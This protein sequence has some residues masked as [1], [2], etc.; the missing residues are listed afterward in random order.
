MKTKLICLLIALSSATAMWA[1]RIWFENLCYETTSDST[2][3]VTYQ[4]RLYYGTENNYNKL[5]SVIIPSSIHD[6]GYKNTY[7]VTGIG[8]YTFDGCKGLTSIIIP[9]GITY[10]GQDAFRGCTGL[11][12]ITMPNSVTRVA[13]N[14]LDDT[15][16]YK[17]QPDELVYINNILYKYKGTMPNNTNVIIKEGTAA[18]C[19]YAFSDC[20]GLTSISIPNSVTG[21]GEHV[22]SGCSGLTSIVVE[23][24][25]TIY[26]SRN[27]CNAII[28]TATNTLMHGCGTTIIPNSVTSI[29]YRA[30]FG[31]TGLTS[32]T[33]PNSVTSIDTY[34]FSD[35]TH[36]TSVTIPNS[37][38]SIGY[39]AFSG[40]TGL[41]SITLP[42]SVTS[43]GNFAFEGCCRLYSIDI[44]NSVTTIGGSAFENCRSLTSITI[45]SNVERVENNAFRGCTSLTSII[46]NA[47]ECYGTDYSV[48]AFKDIASQITSINFGNEV[49]IV[50]AFL[51]YGMQNLTTITLSKSVTDIDEGAFYECSSLVS[52]DI[53]NSVKTIRKYAFQNCTSL[54]SIVISN[55]VTDIGWSAFEGCSGLVSIIIPNSVT[56]IE[57][58]A[59][60]NCTR[61]ASVTLGDNVTN[62]GKEAF[63]GTPWF[64]NFYK[65]QPNGVVY[66]SK[67]LYEYKGTMPANTHLVVK[68]GTAGIN[69]SAF[70]GCTNLVSITIPN[71]VTSIGEY[72]FSGCTGLTSITFPD[73]ITSIGE[74]AFSGCTGLTSITIPKNIKYIGSSAFDDCENLTSV[75]WNA[76]NCGDTRGSSH[77]GNVVS[78][79]TSFT[80]GDD[81]DSI[82]NALFKG[83]TRLTSITIP[84][85]VRK[86][87]IFFD[88]PN[89]TSVVWNAQQCEANTPFY[90]IA[91]QITSFTFGDDVE[92]I[93]KFLCARMSNLTSITIPKGVKSIGDFAFDDCTSLTSVSIG[94]GVTYIGGFSGCSALKSINI[95]KGVTYLGGFRNCTSLTSITLPDGVKYIGDCSGCTALKS[96][97]LPNSVTA[98]EGFS[99]CTAL[100]S[101]AIPD[102]ITDI[103]VDAFFNCSSLS[104]VTFGKSVRTIG[105]S[106]F[107]GCERL[108]SIAFPDSVTTI[109]DRAFNRCKRLAN[110][111][112]PA[113]LTSFGYSVFGEQCTSLKNIVWNVRKAYS[114]Y[115]A[116]NTP[117]YYRVV[118]ASKGEW[119]DI[120]LRS[121][122]VSFTF[123]NDVESIPAGLCAG[124]KKM[125][126]VNLGNSVKSIESEAFYGCQSI[127][128]IT[129]PESLK[130]IGYC[131]FSGCTKIRTKI[132]IPVN[133]S[134][135][136]EDAFAACTGIDSVKWNARNCT[137]GWA[138]H[139]VYS[140]PFLGVL[141]FTFG[142]E[143]ESIPNCLC[144]QLSISSVTIPSRVTSIGFRA[145][146]KCSRLTS[147]TVQAEVPPVAD[148]AAFE[149]VPTD[150]PVYIPCGTKEAY[151][152]AEGWKN[153]TNYIEPTGFTLNVTSR[154][155]NNGTI[156]MIEMASCANS[157]AVFK[158]VAN[159]HYH[160]T[161]WSDGNTDNPRTITLTQDVSLVAEFAPNQYTIT[162]SAQ[163]GTITGGGTYDYGTTATLT[164]IAGEHY[165]FTQWNDG[166]TDN[167]RK[168]TVEG[169]AT[170]TAEFAIDQHT[171]TVNCNPQQGMV[172]GAGIY[173]YGTQVT[174]TATANDGYEFTRWSNG[175]TD[176]PYILTATEDL[177][178][179]AQFISTTAVEDIR[180]NDATAPRKVFRDGQVLI[181]RDGKT[182]TTTGVEVK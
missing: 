110:V 142:D 2:V 29:G 4:R 61:L 169:D 20:T 102:S 35:C 106:A 109:E 163:N 54:A 51:C 134:Y 71:S 133:V 161:R 7:R 117:F 52:V 157:E 85:G 155:L 74:Y 1:E 143:V 92:S 78:Q 23:S 30:F 150:I 24:G 98:F 119:V 115:E 45:P 158:A 68:E 93:P 135:I 44:P 172:T 113:N 127:T 160:F 128:A 151:Q 100:S 11:T 28:E 14:V 84:K 154:D 124:M 132:T 105:E 46:W 165:H 104:S 18:I 8:E 152:S 13:K 146:Y 144:A 95:P 180:A 145:F 12:S 32:I 137:A 3:C 38:T 103:K 182:Y 91:K 33:I 149:E 140:S 89:L 90:H 136:G 164:A 141:Y 82:P 99:G 34:A 178:L 19:S 72:A 66:I 174:L 181:L 125:T 97:N 111:T 67:I 86:C 101:I 36:L 129:F 108:T 47:K 81:V 87:G 17:N 53:P 120:D 121:T 62:I 37:V 118:N 70:K 166:N 139:W 107:S 148:R 48:F 59:F 175:I 79:I 65:N 179:E 177:T 22:F 76:Q 39:C 147:I 80:L 173:D 159:E 64:E 16:W 170:Y 112:F 27:N 73:S 58:Y 176:N 116:G 63:T 42:N 55:S 94:K 126:T 31:C 162:T 167:P 21:I 138:V 25:N 168:I 15:Q 69:D 49:K 171:I 41:T 60:K 75:V 156:E 122:I 6:S 9:D 50:P 26:D 153:F 96:I 43:I 57:G 83:M 130:S 123:G 5:T 114:G 77:F 131:A 10:I 88:C 56:T 40:C